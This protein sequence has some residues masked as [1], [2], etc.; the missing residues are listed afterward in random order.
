MKIILPGGTGLIGNVLARAFHA[1]GDEVVVFSRAAHAASWRVVPWNGE[2]LGDWAREIDGADVLINLAGRSVN[3][4][5]HQANREIIKQSRLRS[6]RVLGD[7]VARA[8]RPP[9]VWLQSS[10]ATIYCHRYDAPNDEATGVLGGE[11][12][13]APDTWNFSIDV[14]KSWEEAFDQLATPGTRKVKMRTAIVMATQRGG[15]FD[16]MLGMVRRGLGG[17]TGD[18]K[19]FVSWIHDEDLIRAVDFLIRRDDLS[20]PVNLASPNPLPNAAF[21]RELREAWGI[22]VGLPASVWMLEVATFLMRTE[23]ELVL[24]SRRVTPTRLLQAGFTFNH[25][26]WLEAAKELCARWRKERA[27]A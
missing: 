22:R 15:A 20:G 5:Y 7:A 27:G 23:S 1:R 19:Q 21:M 14:A 24:K 26:V 16:L 12:P 10:T 3:C 18:G 4:R 25:P 13:G 9:R 6:T 11:E 17:R 8:A 2:T